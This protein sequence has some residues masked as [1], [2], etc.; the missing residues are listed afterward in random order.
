MAKVYDEHAVYPT[1]SARR[2]RS[3]RLLVVLMVPLTGAGEIGALA[4]PAGAFRKKSLGATRVAP[5]EATI[6]HCGSVQYGGAF[7]N[8]ATQITARNTT[9]SVALEVAGR[10]LYDQVH[11]V[12]GVHCGVD[13]CQVGRYHCHYAGGPA[14]QRCVFRDHVVAWSS[15]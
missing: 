14:D 10:L 6:R 4:S 2:R 15:D 13:R 8:S 12:P 7:G 9:C 3:L 1:W 11:Q 5:A